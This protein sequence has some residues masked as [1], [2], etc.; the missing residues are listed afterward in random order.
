MIPEKLI[1]LNESKKIS[2]AVLLVLAAAGACYFVI[3]RNSITRLQDARANYTGMQTVYTETE[4]QQAELPNLQ[5]QLEDMKKQL[6][7]R[8]RQYFSRSEAARF[9]ENINAL[10]SAH[11]LKPVSRVISEPRNLDDGQ[12][13][14]KKEDSRQEFIKIQSAQIT[15]SGNYF[16][17]VDFMNEL[18][19][20]RQ[21]VRLADLH[22]NLSAG[23]DFTP[24]A[25]F[26]IIVIIDSL[27]DAGK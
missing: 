12:T 15:V 10:A 23:E 1:K 14:N 27:K 2:A 20:Y 16:D 3:T 25:L 24:R 18:T 26:E 19:D 21:K 6:Q 4:K 7:E 5:K 11:N 17:I 22:I 13:D 8:Q 9:F